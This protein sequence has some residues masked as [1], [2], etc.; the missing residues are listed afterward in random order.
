M[1]RYVLICWAFASASGYCYGQNPDFS[2]G[3]RSSALSGTNVTLA[4]GWS[5]VNNVAGMAESEITTGRLTYRD[6][7]GI[8][9]LQTLGLVIQHPVSLSTVG[10]GLYRYGDPV[11][12]QQKLSIGAA[13]KIGFISLGL[14]GS[15][16]QYSFEGVG[17][18]SVVVMEFGG[19]ID[20]IPKVTIGAHVFNFNLARIQSLEPVPVIMKIG[21]AYEVTS[22][23]DFFTEVNQILNYDPIFSFGFEYMLVNWMVLRTGVRTTPFSG[24][25]GLGF[26]HKG[27]L[28]DYS[29]SNRQILGNIHEITLGY[30]LYR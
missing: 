10:I 7:Y 13:N 25:A 23:L 5:L 16:L 9:S 11:F 6:R 18:K 1:N 20:L 21:A 29:F 30:D 19:M 14:S 2:L 28:L 15:I 4:D 24:S 12:N 17:T 27:F 22:E 3:A 8:L 26:N